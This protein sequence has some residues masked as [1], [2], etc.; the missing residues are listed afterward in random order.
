M[1]YY[2]YCIK[3]E[4]NGKTYIGQ[5]K[6]KDVNDNYK[7]SGKRLKKSFKKYG[8]ENFTKSILAITGTKENI[9]ILEKYFIALY[10]SEGKAEYNIAA[11]GDGGNGDANRGKIRSLETRQ[12]IREKNL[13]KHL[14]D[15]HKKKISIGVKNSNRV[16]IASEETRKRMSESHKGKKKSLEQIEK[17]RQRQLGTHRSE[18][19]RKRMSEA[20]KGKKHKPFSEEARKRMSESHKGEKN[21]FYGKHHTEE[22]RR[23]I[24]EAQ[25]GI[26][27]HNYGKHFSDEHK[28]KISETMKLTKLKEKQNGTL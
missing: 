16:F 25:K 24:S 21:Y 19:T 15:E 8:L 6:S 17:Q 9:N 23:K 13:G 18:E 26:K 4:I 27:N 14:S 28:R 5:H 11:G 7:G 22:T 3:N 1:I 10:K 12:K 2:I 20:Q